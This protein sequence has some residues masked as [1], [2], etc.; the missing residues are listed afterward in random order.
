MTNTRFVIRVYTTQGKDQI[1]VIAGPMDIALLR[2]RA[3]SALAYVVIGNDQSIGLFNNGAEAAEYTVSMNGQGVTFSDIYPTNFI[4]ELLDVLMKNVNP[5]KNEIQQF[6]LTLPV[7]EYFR[8]S[9]RFHPVAEYPEYDGIS[10]F[11]YNY[12]VNIDDMRLNHLNDYEIEEHWDNIESY[13]EY[14]LH[15][16]TTLVKFYIKSVL[17]WL[18]EYSVDDLLG[19]KEYED[20][21]VKLFSLLEY[22]EIKC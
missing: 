18:S 12:D 22:E 7:L 15:S 20:E 9:R 2:G 10:T 14:R 4:S 11:I 17:E 13:G 1:N 19:V 5:A 6:Q 21:L 8:I 3:G 16:I